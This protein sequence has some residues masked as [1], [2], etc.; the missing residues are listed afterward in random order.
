[1][2]RGGS[3][4][5]REPAEGLGDLIG[6]QPLAPIKAPRVAGDRLPLLQSVLGAIGRPSAISG[7]ASIIEVDCPRNTLLGTTAE[8]DDSPMGVLRLQIV[9][10]PYPAL[11]H[12][13]KPVK[14]VDA[15]LRRVVRRMFDSMYAA[16]GIGLA[17]NQVDL[18]LRLFVVNL[19]ADPNEGEEFVFINPVISRPR[20]S[21]EAEEGCLSFPGLYAQVQRPKQVRIHAFDLA[22]EEIEMELDGLLARVAQHEFDHLDGVVFTDRMSEMALLKAKAALDEFE[23]NLHS[24]RQSGA[25]PSDEAIAARL[26]AWEATYC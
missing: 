3:A 26:A 13:S 25:I 19:K 11:R 7:L 1:M 22:G 14:R 15:E 8:P 5:P 6:W 23:A 18:P 9:A 16:Q 10:Y 24:G 2:S 17:A 12:V 21:E 20:G 4:P